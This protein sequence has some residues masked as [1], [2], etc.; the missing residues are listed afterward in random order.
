MQ[1]THENVFP[2]MCVSKA[3]ELIIGQ[4]FVKRF[5]LCYQSVVCLF[6]SPVCNVGVLWPNGWKDQ[7][8]TWHGGRPGRRPHCVRWRPS[9]LPKEHSSQFSAHVC[10]GW[11]NQ[12][13][14]WQGDKSRPRRYCV[15]WDPAPPGK[16]TAALTFRSIYCGQMAGW[17]KVPLGTE[18]GLPHCVRWGPS[19]PKKGTQ[20]PIFGSCLLWP[21]GWMDHDATWYGGKPLP[22]RRCVKWGPSSTHGKGHSSPTPSFRTMSIVAKRSPISAAAELLCS[23][24]ANVN[25][26]EYTKTS[27]CICIISFRILSVELTTNTN[28][29]KATSASQQL[30]LVNWNKHMSAIFVS[31]LSAVKKAQTFWHVL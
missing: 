23:S 26:F 11:M 29:Q 14:I 15:K 24:S 22:T 1:H 18:L 2:W 31:N 17:I 3:W 27:R 12:D 6:V 5:T 13:A 20:P 7:G 28:A 19:F 10:C 30:A 9:S 16:G 4:P 8:A 25:G 21:N